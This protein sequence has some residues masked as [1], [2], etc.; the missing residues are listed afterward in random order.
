MQHLIREM[1]NQPKTIGQKVRGTL[2][3]STSRFE[4]TEADIRLQIAELHL[5]NDA[6]LQHAGIEAPSD[7]K[8]KARQLVTLYAEERV[9]EHKVE[10]FNQRENALANGSLLEKARR[11]LGDKPENPVKAEAPQPQVIVVPSGDMSRVDAVEKK[12][13]E[14]A[15]ILNQLVQHVAPKEETQEPVA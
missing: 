10:H 6:L 1:N 13:G 11:F 3:V 4:K 5:L 2:P 12:M 8:D 7:L 9:H 14:M 15:D